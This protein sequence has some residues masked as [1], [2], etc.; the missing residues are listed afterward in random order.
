MNKTTKRSLETTVLALTEQERDE[1]R[2][3]LRTYVTDLRMEISHTDRYE[4][5]EEL[6]AKQAVLEEVLGRLSGATPVV[7]GHEHQ[8]EA[9]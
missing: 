3:T 8:R 2:L 1:L 5:R 6:K 4:L 9:G 7:G